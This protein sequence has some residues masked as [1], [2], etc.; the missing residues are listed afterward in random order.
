MRTLDRT[1]LQH[2][3][4]MTAT[5]VMGCCITTSLQFLYQVSPFKHFQFGA[6]LSINSGQL[7]GGRNADPLEIADGI[8]I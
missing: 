4:P 8:S 5:T 7:T 6:G 1:R 3:K 2:D